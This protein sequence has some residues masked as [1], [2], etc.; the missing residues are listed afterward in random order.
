MAAPVIDDPDPL[1][2]RRNP[3]LVG[4]QAV[5]AALAQAARS[6]RLPH[7][8]LIG[9]PRGIGK[10]TLAFRFA[11]W[12]LAGEATAEGLFGDAPPPAGLGIDPNHPIARRIAAAGHADLLTV[13][14]QWDPKRKRLRGEIVAEDARAIAE[15]F[16]LTAAEGGWRIAIVDGAEEMNRHAANGI[17]KILEEPPRRSLLLLV[18]HAPGRLLPTIRSRCRTVLLQPLA[19]SEVAALLAERRAD[20]PPGERAVLAR[21]AE[22]SIGRALEL[23]AV[24]GLELHGALVRVLDT[25]PRLDAAALHQLADSVARGEDDGYR[26]LVDLLLDF[27]Q[28]LAVGGAERVPRAVID[29]EAGLLARL[30]QGRRL[31]AWIDVWEEL[32]ILFARADALSLDRRQTVLDAFLRIEATALRQGVAAA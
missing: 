21:L 16:H 4:H 12:L 26:T 31:E 20:L 15:F 19:E 6:G 7:A 25:L 23:A 24:G 18:S 11:R 9:G 28:R 32:R 13:E 14:R 1:A 3:H 30:A 27:L 17:L 8:I 5:E 22:G 10:A 2:P 29:G